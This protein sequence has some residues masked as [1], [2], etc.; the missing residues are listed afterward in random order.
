MRRTHQDIISSCHRVVACVL[1]IVAGCAIDGSA[2]GDHEVSTVSEE[3]S[4]T[5]DGETIERVP[6]DYRSALLDQRNFGGPVFAVNGTMGIPGFPDIVDG[7]SMLVMWAVPPSG[8][9]TGRITCYGATTPAALRVVVRFRSRTFDSHDGG[10]KHA[11]PIEATS[12]ELD[13]TSA[14]QVGELVEGSFRATLQH[15]TR[16]GEHLEL[17]DFTGKFRL[18]RGPDES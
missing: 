7:A 2:Q 6:D 8:P 15:I 18:A 9:V 11:V 10:Y 13:V 12:C 1:F 5:H 17:G 3:L 4:V 16:T 14:G